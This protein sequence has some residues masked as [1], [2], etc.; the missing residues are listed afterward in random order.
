MPFAD[1]RPGG[2]TGRAFEGPKL[3][4]ALTANTGFLLG[5]LGAGAVKRFA[6]ALEPLG[7]RPKHYGALVL[8]GSRDNMSQQALGEGLGLDASAMVAVVDDLER[9]GFVRRRRDADDRRRYALSL[10]SEGRG[11]LARCRAL[12]EDVDESLMAALSERERRTLRGLLLRLAAGDEGFP[13]AP[14]ASLRS[15][16]S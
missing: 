4:P 2:R 5:K 10:T 6:G 12:A 14:D 16:Q 9:G 11:L 1:E 13:G 15:E 7:L 8:L 3:S